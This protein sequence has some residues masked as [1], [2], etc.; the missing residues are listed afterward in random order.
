MKIAFVTDDGQTISQH[1]GRAQY[2]LVL[3]I[4]DG[5]ITGQELRPKLGHNQFATEPHTE[6]DQSA[7]HGMGS[8]SHDKHIRMADAIRDC[9]LVVCGGMGTGAYQG[10]RFQNIQ[11]LVT[12]LRSIPEA[13]QAYLSGTLQDHTERLH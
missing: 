9:A 11:P 6:H 3:T 13:A 5:K 2:Y 1:F 8:G 4:E 7:G 12:D 10:M